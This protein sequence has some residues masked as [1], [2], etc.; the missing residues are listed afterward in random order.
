MT[1]RRNLTAYTAPGTLY[2]DFFNLSLVGTEVVASVRG[3]PYGETEIRQ[4]EIAIPASEFQQMLERLNAE[5]TEAT[6]QT[7]SWAQNV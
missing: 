3:K 4:L 6:R 7:P 1:D 2:P 5:W